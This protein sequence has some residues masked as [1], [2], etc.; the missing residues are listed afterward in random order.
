MGTKNTAAKRPLAPRQA[1]VYR[2][3]L[4]S[5][6]E[7]GYA[8]SIRELMAELNI[9]SP[10]GVAGHLDN[11]QAKGWI[12]LTAEHARSVVVPEL[13]DAVRAAAGELE[14]RVEVRE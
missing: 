9:K 4:R 12:E 5:Y 11:L 14:G 1:D 10:N 8:P 13:R 3:I 7:R 2:A 6:A